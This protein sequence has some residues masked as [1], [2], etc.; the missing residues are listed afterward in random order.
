MFY[1]RFGSASVDMYL[2]LSYST[3]SCLSDNNKQ[4]LDV[5]WGCIGVIK[6]HYDIVINHQKDTPT[7]AVVAWTRPE[8]D[9]LVL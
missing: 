4:K 9:N 2:A 5:H 7:N 8:F 3:S 6:F 1:L